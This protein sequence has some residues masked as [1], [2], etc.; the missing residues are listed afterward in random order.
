MERAL[1]QFG[2]MYLTQS[3]PAHLLHAPELASLW[4]MLK[5]YAYVYAKW[6]GQL[7]DLEATLSNRRA[8]DG[9]TAPAGGDE[10][11][12]AHMHGWL[13]ELRK[14][15][16]DVELRSAIAQIVRM[17]QNFKPET[18]LLDAHVMVAELRRRI[19]DDLADRRF[20]FVAPD[21]VEY[22][23]DS[24]MLWYQAWM[25]FPS[26][27]FDAE[28]ASKCLALGRHTACVMHLMRVLEVGLR[29]MAKSLGRSGR[30]WGKLLEEIEDE[31]EQ[32]R[33]AKVMPAG[34]R[35]DRGFY[36]EGALQFRHFKD[37]WRND[38][39]HGRRR[40][41][42][43]EASEVYGAVRSFMHHLATRLEEVAEPAT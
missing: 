20:Y 31:L 8:R 26:T 18:H 34:W 6:A 10:L 39:T 2:S 37:A 23:S 30:E 32:R 12:V 35:E 24:A 16:A 9:D 15:A 33:E 38:V 27:Q 36:A 14:R 28:E 17:R 25:K 7:A 3:S 5:A 22:Y 21:R 19:S 41:G 40:F 1:T 29:T 43:E 13:E 42:A 11:D 4:D